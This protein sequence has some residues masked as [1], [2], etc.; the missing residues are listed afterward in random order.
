MHLTGTK[1]SP[2]YSAVVEVQEMFS[3]YGSLL[4]NAMS[5]NVMTL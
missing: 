4:T 3:S 2:L 1:Y 5:H